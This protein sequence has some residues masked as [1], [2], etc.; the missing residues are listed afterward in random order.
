MEK[1]H[2]LK[3]YLKS[4]ISVCVCLYLWVE[5]YIGGLRVFYL[6]LSVGDTLAALVRGT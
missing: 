6:S 3:A 5:I 2:P 4:V 1:L